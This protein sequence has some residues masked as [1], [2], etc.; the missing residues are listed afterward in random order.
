MAHECRGQKPEDALQVIC[1][2]DEQ[3]LICIPDGGSRGEHWGAVSLLQ[4]PGRLFS[5]LCSWARKGSSGRPS[6]IAA[7]AKLGM[8]TLNN[9][10][11]W[12]ISDAI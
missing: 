6:H 3:M 2:P 9:A 12:H 4:P 5:L 8:V 11:T 10:I 7:L 1:I